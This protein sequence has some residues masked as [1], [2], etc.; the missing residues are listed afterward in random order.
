MMKN[1]EE[2]VAILINVI[3]ERKRRVIFQE[4]NKISTDIHCFLKF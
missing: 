4:S 3:L 1:D 2:K